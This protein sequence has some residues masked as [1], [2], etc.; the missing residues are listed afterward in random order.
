M[1][2]DSASCKASERLSI[3]LSQSRRTTT[4]NGAVFSLV[5][6]AVGVGILALPKAMSMA[7]WIGGCFCLVL[8]AI[9]AC[10]CAKMLVKATEIAEQVHLKMSAQD[11]AFC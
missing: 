2:Y 7:G 4:V 1:P 9:F 3:Q 6:T 11:Y 5:T 10:E 8:A